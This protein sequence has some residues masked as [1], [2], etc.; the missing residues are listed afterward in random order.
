MNQP[1]PINLAHEADFALGKTRIRPALRQFA[2]DNTQELIEPRVMQVLVALARR[3]EE[4][5]G[6]DALLNLCW[7]GRVVSEDAIQRAIAKV[8]RLGEASGAFAIETIPK[9]GYRLIP[10]EPQIPVDNDTPV[11]FASEEG[12]A[13]TRLPSIGVLPFLNLTGEADQNCFVDGMTEDIITALSCFREIRTA[14][15]GSTFGLRRKPFDLRE[16]AL[17]LGVHYVLTGTMR[18]ANRRMRVTA[19]LVDCEDRTQVWR[20][21]FDREII[22]VLELQEELSRSVTAVL[23]PALQNAEVERAKRKSVG[24]LSAHDFYLRALP[25]MWAGTKED[26]L[27]AI[28]FLR[29][30]LRHEAS[31]SALA[32]LSFSLLTAPPLGAASPEKTLPEAIHIAHAAIELDAGDAFAQAVYGLA[33]AFNSADRGQIV[34]HTEEAVRLNPSSALAWG[35]LGA[36]RNLTGDFERGLESLELAIRL[37]PSDASLYLWLTFLA[38]ANFALERYEEGVVAARQAVL[39]NPNFG[40]AHRLLAANLALSRN[41]DEARTVTQTRDIVQKTSLGELRNMRLF[42]QA[43]VM[44]RYVAAQGLCGVDD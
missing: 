5:V 9:V 24:D 26:V 2:T 44:E 42:Q 29:Q 19:E 6:R 32:A 28:T 31:A 22:D 33:L 8:R 20:N 13:P 1:A 10:L 41:I 27:K 37:S 40:T 35:C 16:I 36:A 7:A 21:S 39:H 34:L 38:A 18:M 17:D 30:S 25:H 3:A 15:H 4:V 12:V 23:V 11:H 14:P 43:S